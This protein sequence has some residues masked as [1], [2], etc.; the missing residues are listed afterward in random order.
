MGSWI[1]EPYRNFRHLEK[2]FGVTWRD[3]VE[4]EPALEVLLLTAHETSGNCRRWADVDR[5]FVPTGNR[6][7]RLI[8]FAGR[9]HRHPVL[10]S[11]RAYEI[12]YW[13]L[14]EA[15]TGSLPARGREVEAIHSVRKLSP[16]LAITRWPRYV[17]LPMEQGATSNRA[18]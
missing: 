10:G 8:G 13:K 18:G 6:L 11:T 9:N 15:V 1:M 16:T 3:L 17:P 5:F 7:S 4:L 12:A 14:Y 2:L